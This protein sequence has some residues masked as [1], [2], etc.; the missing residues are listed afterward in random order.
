[1][2]LFN[3]HLWP[4]SAR[5]SD[6]SSTV[7]MSRY[8]FLRSLT[9]QKSLLFV[10]KWK[11]QQKIPS[12]HSSFVSTYTTQKQPRKIKLLDNLSSA[13]SVLVAFHFLKQTPFCSSS[14]LLLWFISSSIRSVLV[15]PDSLHF[16][17]VLYVAQHLLPL[18]YHVEVKL[19]EDWGEA[20]MD[21]YITN[22]HHPGRTAASTRE[23][24]FTEKFIRYLFCFVKVEFIYFMTLDKTGVANCAKKTK[25]KSLHIFDTIWFNS[26][27]VMT[28]DEVNAKSEVR[29]RFAFALVLVKKGA[30][31]HL[32]MLEKFQRVPSHAQIHRS[33]K[34]SKPLTVNVNRAS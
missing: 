28:E 11:Q 7:S 19:G 2:V 29:H 22:R 1:M 24:A 17:V 12:V 10:H 21:Q 16:A 23:T 14:C 18:S 33:D 6:S 9:K 5:F 30:K 32:W 13:G 31:V 8:S 34:T 20:K 26:Q 15:L 3:A 25:T 27:I 4:S